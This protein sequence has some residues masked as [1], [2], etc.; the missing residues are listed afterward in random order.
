M[1]FS[2]KEAK[3]YEQQLFLVILLI[4]GGNKL[5]ERIIKSM[6]N[7]YLLLSLGFVEM[8]LQSI[9]IHGRGQGG[10]TIG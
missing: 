7:K 6:E 5:V 4:F 3:S 9:K 2:L 10:T 8:F 1:S